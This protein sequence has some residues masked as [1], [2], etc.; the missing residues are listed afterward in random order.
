[1]LTVRSI[2]FFDPI[3]HETH[4]SLRSR[5]DRSPG[6]VHQARA[7][8]GAFPCRRKSRRPIHG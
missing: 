3:G 1:M 2:A 7:C 4:H 5:G 8:I 6:G